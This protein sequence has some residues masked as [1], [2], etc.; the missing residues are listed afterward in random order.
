MAQALNLANWLSVG[1]GDLNSWHHRYACKIYIGE[2]LI[3]RPLLNII[4]QIAKTK[5]LTK[6]SRYRV[7][8]YKY[9]SNV[10]VNHSPV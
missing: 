4:C 8:T 9:T 1:I 5:N 6:V 10:L 2:F 3:W 7:L